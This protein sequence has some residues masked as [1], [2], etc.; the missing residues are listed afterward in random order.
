MKT[1]VAPIPVWHHID[2]V[3]LNT[4]ADFWRRGSVTCRAT[5]V[6]YTPWTRSSENFRSVFGYFDNT[7]TS[8]YMLTFHILNV[9]VDKTQPRQ[10]KFTLMLSPGRIMLS[11]VTKI[12]AAMTTWNAL[13]KHTVCPCRTGTEFAIGVNITAF[14]W[15]FRAP[16]RFSV[17]SSFFYTCFASIVQCIYLY[18]FVCFACLEFKAASTRAST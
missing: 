10:F 13:R 15:A 8:E 11:K 12:I 14:G 18:Y 4:G 17:M 6:H 1:P 3:R 9:Y 16:S 7:V 5:P 2:S